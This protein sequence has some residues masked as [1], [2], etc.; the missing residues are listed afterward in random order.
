[1]AWSYLFGLGAGVS[2]LAIVS[3][4]PWAP[5]WSDDQHKWEKGGK[6]FLSVP[7]IQLAYWSLNLWP[8]HYSLGEG[9]WAWNNCSP[10]S[11]EWVV[12]PQ[13]ATTIHCLWSLKFKICPN[14]PWITIWGR[15]GASCSVYP[16]T[17]HST[18]WVMES[19][20]TNCIFWSFWVFPCPIPLA[21]CLPRSLSK[22]SLQGPPIN[23][24]CSSK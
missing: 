17:R 24:H 8:H 22:H 13:L 3:S 2:G 1:M 5:P 23:K 9:G 12:Q 7:L 15:E 18:N 21:I 10:P 20:S 14:P 11:R 16:L 6:R 19:S 4:H